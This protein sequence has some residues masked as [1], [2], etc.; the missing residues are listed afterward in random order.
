MQITYL[1]PTKRSWA[2]GDRAIACVA[3]FDTQRTASIKGK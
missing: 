2:Q 1:Y 3:T